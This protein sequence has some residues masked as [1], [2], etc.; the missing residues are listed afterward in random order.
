M[1][2]L[3]FAK[4]YSVIPLLSTRMRPTGEAPRA[5]LV[6]LVFAASATARPAAV[7]ATTAAAATAASNLLQFFIGSPCGCRS[8]A[9]AG[10]SV[11]CTDPARGVTATRSRF[12]GPNERVL[13]KTR[14]QRF[15]AT[16]LAFPVEVL[17]RG[18]PWPR[19]T[20]S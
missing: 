19:A 18:E 9:C 10:R 14:L 1:A 15:E 20:S 11:G 12:D 17:G 7:T 6:A 5:I 4:S 16:A 13:S 3:S 2:P 8:T